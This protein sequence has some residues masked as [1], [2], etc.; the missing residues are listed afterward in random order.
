PERS[1][2]PR[3]A[4]VVGTHHQPMTRKMLSSEDYR[5]RH[6]MLF[7]RHLSTGAQATAR[8]IDASCEL[9]PLEMRA[10]LNSQKS[11]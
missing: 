3:G 4:P 11:S 7:F 6:H 5:G 2:A 10:V 1:A 8:G 9:D